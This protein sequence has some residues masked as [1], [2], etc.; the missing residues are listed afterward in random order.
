MIIVALALNTTRVLAVG[1][2]AL[3]TTRGR[4]AAKAAYAWLVGGCAG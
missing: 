2:Y 4:K 1:H 3:L